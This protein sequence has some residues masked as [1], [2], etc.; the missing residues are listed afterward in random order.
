MTITHSEIVGSRRGGI[1]LRQNTELD[2]VFHVR[3]TDVLAD[4]L[5]HINPLVG[6]TYTDPVTGYPLDQVALAWEHVAKDCFRF[7][8]TFGTDENALASGEYKLSF[9]TTGQTAHI[10]AAKADVATYVPAGKSTA[11][12]NHQQLIG[13]TDNGE[14][15][16]VDIVVPCLRFT[17]TYK[18]PKATITDAYVRL[19]EAMTGTYNSG[20][21]YG[22]S[23]GEVLFLGADGTQGTKVD[24]QID[25]QFLRLPNI[26]GLT[27]GGITG[28]A[29]LG[30]HYMWVE[31]EDDPQN[32]LLKKPA[33]VHICRVYDS[34]NFAL[35]G[36]G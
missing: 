21:F 3:G 28:I 14:V 15:A 5:A 20:T 33:A 10:K 27:I 19:L 6:N 2:L 32:R 13:V 26:T 18:Q 30:H 34:A 25:Y 17:V 7:T 31:Y 35:L 36:I 24:P 11:D 16:G 12:Y 4:A 1:K 23:A 22:R 29:K 8:Y 9:G